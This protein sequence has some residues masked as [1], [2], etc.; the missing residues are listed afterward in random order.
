MS[1]NRRTMK[2]FLLI[3]CLPLIAAFTYN[4][5]SNLTQYNAL[6]S[7]IKNA[8]EENAIAFADNRSKATNVDIWTSGDIKIRFSG[9][10]EV[11][12]FN[13]FELY[14]TQEYSFGISLADNQTFIRFNFSETKY[15]DINFRTHIKAKEVYDAFTELIL[16]GKEYY[17]P[18][19]DLNIAETTDSINSLLSRYA[20]FKPQIRV[21]LKGSVIIT[22]TNMQFFTFNL[23]ELSSSDYNEGFEVNGIEMIPCTKRNVGANNW[24]K[25]NAGDRTSA[26]LKF[27]CI[28]DAELSKIHQLLIHLKTSVTRIMNS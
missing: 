18:D 14:K 22:N 16:S 11:R 25:F 27:D 19:I 26:F 1:L 20:A 24:I 9:D 13:L 3:A 21:S 7:Q 8:I 28:N 4:S 2:R 15:I 10:S 6:A 17:T 12:M 5:T 23:Q